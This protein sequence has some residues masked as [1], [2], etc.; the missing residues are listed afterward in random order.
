MTLPSRNL[1]R[2][3]DAAVRPEKIALIDLAAGGPREIT[4]AALDAECDAV[5]RGL[6]KTGLRRG[7]RV[8]ILS[9]NR[10]ELLAVFFG[11]MRAGLVAVPISFKLAR[12]TV[13]HIV[14]DSAVRVVFHDPAR[15]DLCP[16]TVSGIDFDAPDGYA[17]LR[18][19]GPFDTREPTSRELAMIL[20]T[21]GSTGQPKGVLLSH[22]SQAWSL[23]TS[24]ALYGD[25]SQHRYLVGAPMFHM[26]ATISVMG[27]LSSGASIVMLPAFDATLYA[28]A[29]ERY[30]VTW[31]TSVPTMLVLVAKKRASMPGLDFSSVTRVT[32][33]SAPLTQALV[34]KVQA[35]FP[36][37]LI[38]NS[39]GTTEAGPAPFGP[40]PDGIARP[41]TACG[42]PVPG[43][44][45]ELR[46]GPDPD[47]GVLYMKSPMLMEGYN[48]LPAQTARTMHD[49][50][51]RSGDIMRRDAQGFF[52]FL[53]R[54]DD[55][56]VV[57]GENVWPA[58]VEKL[59]E[60]MPGVLQAAVV[61]VADDI[62]GALPFAFVV[63]QPGATVTEADIKRFTLA[64]GPAFAHPR[65][66]EFLD[67]IPLAGA[68]KPDRRRL[69]GMAGTLVAERRAL[70]GIDHVVIL[71]ADLDANAQGYRKLGF[72][73]SPKAEHSAALG[74]ANHTIMLQQDYF[75]LLAVTCAT[76]RNAPWR[77]A[78]KD[79]GG[80]AGAAL[81]TEDAAAARRLWLDAGFSPHEVIGFSRSVKRGDGAALEARF[82]AVF[83]PDMAEVGVRIFACSQ[84]TRE[85]VWLP[86][87]MTHENTAQA[88][89]RLTIATADPQATAQAWQRTIP[90][91][92]A[93]AAATGHCVLTV[94]TQHIDFIRY[95]APG[96]CSDST[97]P[98]RVRAV[99]IT[100]RVAD[101]GACKA[102]LMRNQVP[103][104][105]ERNE[106][107]VPSD[108]AGNVCIKFTGAPTARWR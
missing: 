37:A 58:E 46:E 86:E 67:D 40:H 19:P 68:N 3:F 60:R 45:C 105:E 4:Y 57:G 77:Q 35:I 9:L 66:V 14:K 76:E 94:G 47:Q 106:L 26:N 101:L 25:R 98:N 100:Y 32:M 73:L 31:L 38:N 82:E 81:T 22:E 2:C 49:G 54:A 74:T 29:I 42:Y 59:V 63:R 79:G 65:F 13:A 52:H 69:I 28:E 80:I 53:G 27:A 16:D 108:A 50:W 64:G 104:K 33:G 39:Y 36:G 71:V 48:N 83:L 6:L 7:D 90:A 15:A 12:E 97:A 56:F 23:D 78:L 91:L 20:Y 107:V 30:R 17:R 72:T 102:V 92:R 55:M 62:K 18:D 24:A 10:F 95:E 103:F 96:G 8:G 34:D 99:G 5:A 89:E 84:P 51:Y 75:E 88:I 70:G 1:G 41:A 87:L 43:S 93:G 85:A 61:P 21:S 44:H 11:A